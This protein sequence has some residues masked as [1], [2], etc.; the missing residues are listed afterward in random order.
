MI[1]T[2]IYVLTIISIMFLSAIGSIKIFKKLH[3]FLAR[4]CDFKNPVKTYHYK[5]I[6]VKELNCNLLDEGKYDKNKNVIF[7]NY[8]LPKFL[9][10]YIVAHEYC[11]ST[12]CGPRFTTLGAEIRCIFLIKR[13]TRR[14]RNET[15]K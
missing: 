2:L 6:E 12:Y 7:I 13:K 4:R 3:I 8:K 14:N 5:N 11:H 1:E 15:F 9:K 10:K